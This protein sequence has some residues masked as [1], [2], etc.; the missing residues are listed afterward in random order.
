MKKYGYGES[1]YRY[2]G[3]HGL[4]LTVNGGTY[5]IGKDTVEIEPFEI[6]IES[7]VPVVN[8]AQ[9]RWMKR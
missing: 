3:N 2:V 7:F 6:Y 9:E 8:I 4:R 5:D 1:D